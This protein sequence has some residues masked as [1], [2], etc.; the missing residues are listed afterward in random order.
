M[1]SKHTATREVTLLKGAELSLEG[2]GPA[3]GVPLA[4]VGRRA[5]WAKRLEDLLILGL[6]V[7]WA[8]S[9][10]TMLRLT[11]AYLMSKQHPVPKSRFL[12]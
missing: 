5:D 1:L 7:H 9:S 2:E 3:E 11:S 8:I 10:A 12:G 6:K 4:V